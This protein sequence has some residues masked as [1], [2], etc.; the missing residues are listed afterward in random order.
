MIENITEGGLD[1][2]KFNAF[3]SRKKGKN[4][5]QINQSVGSNFDF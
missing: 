2:T 5:S 1:A 4:K 3:L